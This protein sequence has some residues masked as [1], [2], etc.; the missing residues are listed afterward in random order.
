MGR[1][2]LEGSGPVQGGLAVP[3][4]AGFYFPPLYS[5]ALHGRPGQRGGEAFDG[6]PG[7]LALCVSARGRGAELLELTVLW[8]F[9][10]EAAA[11]LL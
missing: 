11:S 2:P 4:E 8:L 9:T 7:C 10:S 5:S 3:V 6:T 1:L